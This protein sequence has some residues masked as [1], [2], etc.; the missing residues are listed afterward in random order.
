M[1]LDK[2]VECDDKL[3]DEKV[4]LCYKKITKDCEAVIVI[5]GERRELVNL[6]LITTTGE[7]PAGGSLAKARE[8]CLEKMGEWLRQ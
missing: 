8:Y 4:T 6:R 1:L 5:S 2:Q 7:D 3:E